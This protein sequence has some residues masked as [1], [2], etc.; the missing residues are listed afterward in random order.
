[1]LPLDG[2]PLD[3]NRH[4]QFEMLEL[5][6]M[7]A[8]DVLVS[9]VDGDLRVTGDD[10]DN[11]LQIQQLSSSDPRAVRGGV[12]FQITPDADTSINRNDAGVGIVVAGVTRDVAIDM[13]DG[14][15]DLTVLGANGRQ[16]R[17]LLIDT[18]SGP[19]AVSI[20]RFSLSRDIRV[21]DADSL[22]LSLQQTKSGDVFIKIDDIEGESKRSAATTSSVTIRDSR[23]NGGANI[24]SGAPLKVKIHGNIAFPDVC[25][26]PAPPAPLPPCGTVHVSSGAPLSLDMDQTRA[27]GLFIKIDDIEGESNDAPA[28]PT[29]S[30]S[31][32]NSRLRSGADISSNA[33]LAVD[34]DQTRAAG[35]FIKIDDI[36]G[37]AKDAVAAPTSSITI[38]NS[39]LR[40]DANISS[41]APLT[42]DMDQ[43][44][45]AGVF[46][47]IDDIKG[48]AK[49]AVAAPTSS[50]TIRNS[51]LRGDANISSNAPLTVVMDQTRAAGVFIKID[52]IEGE[53]RDAAAA[54]TS[55]VTIRKSRL[56]GDADISSNVPLALTMDQTK[57]KGEVVIK[58][59]GISLSSDARSSK[60]AN[61]IRIVD[62]VFGSLGVVG[63]ERRDELEIERLR[64]LGRTHIET[65][66]GDDSLTV[67]DTMFGGFAFLDGGEDTDSL[68]LMGTRFRHGSK[69][70]NWE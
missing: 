45:A 46:I 3:G 25:K 69:I 33:P 35:V 1:M 24:S 29:S 5:R 66:G 41:N 57:A 30:I 8:G 14:R 55:S 49:D 61:S 32:R 42:V 18:G 43:T 11:V 58:A 51:R 68:I 2:L 48:E 64:V 28:A 53:S 34:M 56:R 21:S 16:L 37:E 23:L 40:G 9:V 38:R 63:S 27:A 70:V 39:R 15:D 60:F 13:G 20:T 67:S 12:S 22:D 54:S 7:L 17:D 47:K 44:R 19:D 52:D 62:S 59:E 31:I 50:I 36:K 6:A 4:L 65:G 10:Q 26:T